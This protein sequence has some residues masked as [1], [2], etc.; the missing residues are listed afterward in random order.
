MNKKI[1]LSGVHGVG[2][3]YFIESMVVDKYNVSIISASEVINRYKDCEDAGN[4]RVKDVQENQ[5]IILDVLRNVNCD[6]TVVLDGHLIIIS[7]GD[8]LQRIPEDYFKEGLFDTIILLQDEPDKIHKRLYKRDGM[9]K[10]DLS[11]ISKIQEEELSYAEELRKKGIALYIITP[12]VSEEQC[13]K[14]FG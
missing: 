12:E 14:I 10:I 2:K 7:E 13:K 8:T 3:G 6:K 5:D 9:Y 11:L 1:L 4:K